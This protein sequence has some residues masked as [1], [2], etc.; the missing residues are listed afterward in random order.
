MEHYKFFIRKQSEIEVF[1]KYYA[2][3]WEL[4]KLCSFKDTEE[5]LLRTQIILGICE[6]DLQARFIRE[7]LPLDKVVKYCQSTEQ[8]EINCKLII[9]ENENKVEQERKLST[10]KLWE[11]GNTKIN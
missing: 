3:L 5:V 1:D 9:H 11:S 10:R 8:G 6:K 2:V 4:I 7:D